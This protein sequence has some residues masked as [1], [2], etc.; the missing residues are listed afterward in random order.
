MASREG[1]APGDT[2]VE[3]RLEGGLVVTGTVVD[4]E[5]KPFPQGSVTAQVDGAKTPQH[6]SHAQVQGNGTFRL[7]GLRSVPYLIQFHRHDSGP[8]PEP[9]RLTPPA[10]NVRI[11]LPRSEKVA[12]RLRGTGELA[13]FRVSAAPDSNIQQ[14]RRGARTAS[15]GAFT[16][17][18][19]GGGPQTLMASK[20]GD[21]RYGLL[22][23]VA[24]GTTDAALDLQVGQSISGVVEAPPGTKVERYMVTF[25][26]PSW[27]GWA[28]VNAEGAFVARGLPP[29][30]YKVTAATEAGTATEEDV[31]SGT[32]G[33]RLRIV[34]R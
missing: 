17:E 13:G 34:G 6:H 29:G 26:S 8:S 16:I 25:V 11:Q 31:A 3:I 10:S 24:P 28:R 21:D 33:L 32:T 20:D 14:Q 1:V 12:G 9:T 7:E 18:G 4:V 22:T 5:G 27:Y 30:R 2:G 23:G 19:V 15:D